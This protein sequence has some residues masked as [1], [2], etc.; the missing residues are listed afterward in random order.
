VR[1]VQALLADLASP[2]QREK[3]FASVDRHL[4]GPH[5]LALFHPAYGTWNPTL[6]RISMFSEGTKEN[7]AV[8]CHAATFM[9]VAELMHGRGTTAYEHLKAIMPNAQADYDL[10]KTEPYVYAEYLVGPQ[11]PYRYGEGAF[12]WMTGTA[13]WTFLAAT[14]WL[15]GARRDYEGLRIDPCLPTHWKRCRIVRPFRGATYDI[16]ILNPHRLERGV[17]ALEVDGRPIAGNLIPPHGDGK[18]HT[19]RAILKRPVT[20]RLAEGAKLRLTP[21]SPF[22]KI[23]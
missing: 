7:A 21:P 3:I 18:T 11:N 8:F 14:E 20:G 15:L 22:A 13:G 9:I 1:A 6:G 12:T 4:N 23:S 5:G 19:V 2:E 16:E 10:Y 17:V